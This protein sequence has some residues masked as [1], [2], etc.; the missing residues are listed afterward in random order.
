MEIY[1]L[2]D[3]TNEGSRTLAYLECYDRLHAFYFEL[4]PD[5]DPWDL[6]FILHEYARRGQHTIDAAWSA[7]WVRSRLVPP[8]R[9]NLGEV[10]S[11]NGLTEYDELRL[12]R[13]TEGRCS[14][15]GCYLVPASRAELPSWYL[16]R[17]RRR[18]TDVYALGN[19]RLLATFRDG[20]VSLCDMRPL[21]EAKRPFARVLADESVFARVSLE[22][23][24]HGARWG[25]TLA[26]PADEIRASGQDLPL[27]AAD[28]RGLARQAVCDSA[29]AANLLGCTRQN[30]SDLVRR[31]KLT[32]LKSDSRGALFLR[33]DLLA[34]IT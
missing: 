31:G 9:Q 33:A 22:A 1:A 14:Q 2:H 21:L 8:E 18:M 34:R 27:G 15:D 28:V 20:R 26:V 23:G 3:E 5:A 13:L 29:E 30:I 16:E 12:L 17:E 11:E 6:P 32:P 25:E 4:P 19:Q 7:T 10:L 24:G